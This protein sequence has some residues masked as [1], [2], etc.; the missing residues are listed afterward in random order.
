MSRFGTICVITLLAM[1]VGAP[2]S[3]YVKHVRYYAPKTD[4]VTNSEKL[5][6]VMEKSIA[7]PGNVR[8]FYVED[9]K[10]SVMVDP[11]TDEIDPK[12]LTKEDSVELSFVADDLYW[13][14]EVTRCGPKE[15]LAGKDWL[16]CSVNDD[17]TGFAIET[18]PGQ[19]PILHFGN[20]W[21]N[22]SSTVPVPVTYGEEAN[23]LVD[24]RGQAA[25]N[26]LL[27]TG[28]RPDLVSI[29]LIDAQA[30]AITTAAASKE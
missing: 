11:S 21:Q 13:S 18:K 10:L 12:L 23:Y 16:F 8:R 25:A 19:Q 20:L 2:A 28:E 3:A 27:V 26:Q 1:M 29:P 15:G 14:I 22:S 30:P 7:N 4:G 9:L 6:F 5:A 17:K 24:D